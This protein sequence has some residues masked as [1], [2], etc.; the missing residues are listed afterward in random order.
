MNLGSVI[1]THPWVSPFRDWTGFSGCVR[2]RWAIRGEFLVTKVID[3]NSGAKKQ[4]TPLVSFR[5][6][7]EVWTLLSHTVEVKNEVTYSQVW[8]PILGISA[9]HLSHPK[10]THTA[11][12]THTPGAVGSHLYCSARWGFGALLKGTSVVVLKVERAL[13]V[14][15]PHLKFLPD[16]DSNSQPFNH[17]S[18]H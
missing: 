17:E 7:V 16:R 5:T 11:V 2:L 9:L 14:H 3:C 4:I 6:L 8:W 12:N 1:T 18:N 10:C 13:Y 15:S